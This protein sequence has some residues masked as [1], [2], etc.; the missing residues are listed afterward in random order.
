MG[1]RGKTRNASLETTI[2]GVNLNE[3]LNFSGSHILSCK[4]Q[5]LACS[6]EC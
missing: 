1:N 5:K 4:I 2:L 6:G 3:L